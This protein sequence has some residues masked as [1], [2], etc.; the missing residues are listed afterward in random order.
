MGQLTVRFRLLSLTSSQCTLRQDSG[1][2]QIVGFTGI[3]THSHEKQAGITFAWGKSRKGKDK[4]NVRPGEQARSWKRNQ[5]YL[6]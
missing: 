5:S 4:K 1:G 2:Q 6:E 3:R